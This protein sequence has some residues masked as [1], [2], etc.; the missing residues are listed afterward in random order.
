MNVRAIATAAIF[1]ACLRPAAAAAQAGVSASAL[2]P[3]STLPA[4]VGTFNF[5]ASRNVFTFPASFSA[6]CGSASIEAWPS[7]VLR[8][9]GSNCPRPLQAILRYYFRFAGPAN[10]SVWRYVTTAHAL[11]AA[12]EAHAGYSLTVG[13]RSVDGP[14][15]CPLITNTCG[16]RTSSTLFSF[17]ANRAYEVSMMAVVTNFLGSGPASAYLDPVFSL[18]PGFP[19]AASYTLELSAGVGNGVSAVPE[20]AV[21]PMTLLGL[22]GLAGLTSWRRRRP[23]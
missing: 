1:L 23:G 14:G 22:A 10:T 15:D 9:S 17:E 21:L 8:V 11:D 3:P 4:A 12:D 5:D 20:P 16:F 18:A 7:P 19:D 13:G 2:P 6:S